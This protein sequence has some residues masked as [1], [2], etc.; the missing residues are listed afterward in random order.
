MRVD[1]KQIWSS[2]RSTIYTNATIELHCVA[3]RCWLGLHGATWG[4]LGLLLGSD[5]LDTKLTG[6]TCSYLEL[7]GATWGYPWECEGQDF[8]DIC[9]RSEVGPPEVQAPFGK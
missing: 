6:A 1:I 5:Y 7:P 2:H 4:Y 9:Y 3:L 8:K